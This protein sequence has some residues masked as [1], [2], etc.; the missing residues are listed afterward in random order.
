M[1]KPKSVILFLFLLIIVGIILM[2]FLKICPPKG[3]WPTPPW[4]NNKH[5]KNTYEIVTNPVA[6]NKIK[7]V[8]MSDTWGRNYNMG[9]FETT[10]DNIE[11]SFARV[12]KLGAEEVYVHDFHRAIFEKE[13]DYTTT[14]YKIENETFWNDF[15][16]ESISEQDLKKL[17][18]LAHKNNL[19]L[20]IK[21]NMSFV[22]IG[23]YMIKGLFGDIQTSVVSD[24]KN[25]NKEHT[26]EWIRDYFEKWTSRLMDKARLYEKY[27][28]DILSI[29]PTWMEP[30]FSGHEELANELQK[31][32]I[33]KLKSVYSGK[34]YVELNIYGF[35]EDINGKEDYKKYDYYTL[36]DIVEIR[37]YSFI[38][39]YKNMELEEGINL[40]LTAIDNKAKEKN[41]KIS[42][43][44]APSS[45]YDSFKNGALEVLDYKSE[46]VKNTEKDYEYQ[47][48]IFELFLKNIN[49][50][51]NIERLNIASF[52]WDDLLD[53]E[54]KPKISIGS[55]FRNKPAESLIELWFNK[56]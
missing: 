19:K 37:I 51:E 38:E 29:S 40:Y 55:T 43:F 25:F 30:T 14:A 32:L 22:D 17:A 53:P 39:K 36:A 52:A 12:S 31:K 56:K 42:I 45:Y 10:Q 1:K 4:C 21:H 50:F 48:K 8:N 16:D 2:F 34:I 3:P 49:N 35:L 15:R 18:D 13:K 23:K 5:S 41:I 33:E 26:E 7:A 47:N 27:G 6:I 28:V 44:L 9:M 11:E 54:I 20:G 24:Y 46:I